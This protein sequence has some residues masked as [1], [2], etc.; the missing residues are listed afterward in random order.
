MADAFAAGCGSGF[1]EPAADSLDLPAGGF[2]RQLAILNAPGVRAFE[3]VLTPVRSPTSPAADRR[4][5]DDASVA[6][7]VAMS[8]E[9]PPPPYV[10]L[11]ESDKED[12]AERVARKLREAS[13]PVNPGPIRGFG[14]R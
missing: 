7:Y 1:D 10:M 5:G 12:I 14:S 9:P 8:R 3:S 2:A 4:R 11:T 6:R 13:E